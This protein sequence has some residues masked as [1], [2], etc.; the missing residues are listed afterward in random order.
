MFKSYRPW[1][2]GDTL[3]V[4]L[5]LFSIAFGIYSAFSDDPPESPTSSE[6]LS[7][8]EYLNSDISS[9]CGIDPETALSILEAYIYQDT[10]DYIPVSQD[11]AESALEALRI[12]YRTVSK[13]VWDATR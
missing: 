12:Y 13:T 1:S 3:A 10:D 9:E 6:Y 2:L 5:I 8:L 7:I 4:I 11:D